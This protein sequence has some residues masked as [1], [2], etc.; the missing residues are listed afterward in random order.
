M[1]K[2]IKTIVFELEFEYYL[3][4]IYKTHNIVYLEMID[5]MVKNKKDYL[6]KYLSG[7]LMKDIIDNHE[8]KLLKKLGKQ[9]KFQF[10]DI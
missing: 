6:K 5:D 8:N 1:I 4:R 2:F 9:R 3:R 10:Y 7:K